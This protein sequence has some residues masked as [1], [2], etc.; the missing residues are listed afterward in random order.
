MARTL[1]LIAYDVRNPKRL[2]RVHKVLKEF[3]TGGQKSAFECYLSDAERNELLSRVRDQMDETQDALLIVALKD[4]TNVIV[5]GIAVAP[6][7]ETLTYL[8]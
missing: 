7:N 8:G 3:A 4:R 1:Y 5:K 2:R 6:S